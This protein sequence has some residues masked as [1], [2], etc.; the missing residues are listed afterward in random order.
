MPFQTQKKLR[1]ELVGLRVL[2]F[3][4]GVVAKGKVVEKEEVMER[5]EVVEKEKV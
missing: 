3:E 5:E 4:V 1:M 2:G